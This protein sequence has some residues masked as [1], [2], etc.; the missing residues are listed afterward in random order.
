MVSR[1]I[2]VEHVERV[3]RVLQRKPLIWDNLHANDY[4]PKRIFL[5]PFEGRPVNLKN[6]ISGLL[7]NPNTKYEANFI[8]FSTFS[9]WN[10]SESDVQKG[11]KL[12]FLILYIFL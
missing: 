8:P 7:L 9:D 2:T 1:Y 6:H 12:I 4:D 11:I 5:G 3:A 10:Q